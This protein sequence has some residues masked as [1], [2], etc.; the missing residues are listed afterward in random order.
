MTKAHVAAHSIVMVRYKS[1][2]LLRR[3]PPRI[4]DGGA[5]NLLD[6]APPPPIL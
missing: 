4:G 6:L 1:N 5:V 2:S 3:I